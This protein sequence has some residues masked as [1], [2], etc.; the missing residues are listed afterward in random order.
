MWWLA[1]KVAY[2]NVDTYTRAYKGS[3]MIWELPSNNKIYYKTSDNQIVTPY[4]WTGGNTGGFGA[5][6]VSNTYNDGIGIITFDGPVTRIGNLAFASAMTRTET[7]NTVIIPDTVTSLEGSAFDGTLYPGNE[8]NTVNIPSSITY[9]GNYAFR[10]CR[11]KKVYITQNMRIGTT[12]WAGATVMKIEVDS[13]NTVYDSRNNSNCIIETATN[14]LLQGCRNTIIPSTVTKIGE[15]AFYAQQGMRTITL[16]SSITYIGH[17]AFSEC[18]SLK[19][20]ISNNPTPPTW[21]TTY[22]VFRGAA[23]TSIRVPAGSVN[24]YKSAPGWSTYA[25][26]IVAQ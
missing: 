17:Q 16:P 5:N 11:I 6:I 3:E 1:D 7:L 12:P 25:D 26:K 14:T 21:Q 8:I 9:I 18:L 4:I 24:D 15:E 20:V 13:N 19:E 23:I 22:L 10:N 2:R